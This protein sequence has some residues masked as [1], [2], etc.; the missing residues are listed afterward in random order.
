MAQ[1]I[2]FIGLGIMGHPMAAHLVAGD[3]HLRGRARFAREPEDEGHEP[4]VHDAAPGEVRILGVID[5]DLV[6]L[7]REIEVG[8]CRLV[9]IST[10][11]ITET[12]TIAAGRAWRRGPP[13]GAGGPHAFDR[14][15]LH[16]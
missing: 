12:N 5:H 1:S 15:P 4:R 9:T 8:Y 2:G 3:H 13:A 11:N 10:D 7:H 6:E 16:R 14:E